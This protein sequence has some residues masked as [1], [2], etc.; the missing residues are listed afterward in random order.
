MTDDIYISR[1]PASVDY[2]NTMSLAMQPSSII[3]PIRTAVDQEA[4]M[5]MENTSIH[6]LGGRQV[7]RG[8]LGAP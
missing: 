7:A 4:V 2:T 8:E 1:S 6:L 5:A 3:A